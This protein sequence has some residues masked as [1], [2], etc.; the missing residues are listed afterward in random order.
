VATNIK[1]NIVSSMNE[2]FSSSTS[3]VVAH[4]KGLT[5]AEVTSLRRRMRSNGAEF[6]VVKNTLASLS[7]NG[8]QFEPLKSFFT[9]PTAIAYSNDPV[10]AAKIMVEYAK[11]NEKLVI[12]GG[13]VEAQVL[14]LSQVQ[15]LATL[16]SLDELRAK[17][18]GIITTPATRVAG[19]VQAVPATLARVFGAY[20]SKEN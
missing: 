7:V 12:L 6:K 20:A 10:S 9:G 16:P 5:V 13:M 11:E 8:T 19:V 14:N 4:Y 17:I 1:K 2:V 15:S 18:I 3:V